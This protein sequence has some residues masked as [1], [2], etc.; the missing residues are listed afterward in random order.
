MSRVIAF[1]LLAAGLLAAVPASASADEAIAETTMPTPLAAYGGWTAWSSA[2]AGGRYV[3]RLR[4]PDGGIRDAPLP[5]SSKPWDVSLGPDAGGRAVAIYRRCRPTGC[6][7]DS[8]DLASGRIERLRAVSSP[9]FD[10]ATPAIW[11]ST[12]VF[13]RRVRRCDV[14]Y[15]KDLRSSA[16][17]RRLLRSK[18]LQTA[19]GQMSIRGTRIIASSIDMSEADEHGAGIKTSEIRRYSARTA[20]S[21]VLARQSFGEESNLFGQVAQSDRFVWTV[22]IGVHGPNVF[23]RIPLGAGARKE[24]PSWRT[25]GA[26]FARTPEQGYVYVELQDPSGCS[27]FDSVPCRIVSSPADPFG[28]T[29]R[30]LT[31]ELTVAYTGTPRAGQ[32]LAFSGRLTRRSVAGGEILRTEPLFGVSVDLRARIGQDPERFTG[33]GLTAT[34]AADGSWAIT[35]PSLTGLPWYTAVAA[36]PGVVTWAGRGTVGSTMP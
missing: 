11:R 30:V 12:V 25:L 8:L 5:S 13:T 15:V 31:P 28:S 35:L 16:P 36:T 9:S 2:D 21:S 23:V 32:P 17:S 3:L 4:G 24:V 22:R 34:T 6:D 18:C 10:E 14:P 1:L 20:G 26:G 27:T 19:A 33:T 29:V 7:I